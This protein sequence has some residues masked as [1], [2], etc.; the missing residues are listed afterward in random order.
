M[1]K[2]YLSPVILILCLNSHVIF[3]KADN[4]NKEQP[5]IVKVSPLDK[6]ALLRSV[7]FVLK[8]GAEGH[9]VIEDKNCLDLT[10]NRDS[11]YLV[12]RVNNSNYYILGT[13]TTIEGELYKPSACYINESKNLTKLECVAR[14]SQAIDSLDENTALTF[15]M[16]YN[17]LS[18]KKCPSSGSVFN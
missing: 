2:L 8:D 16:E 7:H 17:D 18:I 5:A 6:E 12:A 3:G 1:R 9:R 4:Q 11:G 14:S 10:F 13:E 15:Y